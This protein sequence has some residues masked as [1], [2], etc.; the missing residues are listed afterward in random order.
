MQ[1]KAR[2]MKRA[3][4]LVQE[5]SI[6]IVVLY[7]PRA[8][9]CV[10]LL[11]DGKCLRLLEVSGQRPVLIEVPSYV[12]ELDGASRL[13]EGSLAFRARCQVSDFEF[14]P[15]TVPLIERLK[16]FHRA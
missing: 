14:L 15:I 13:F 12:E 11:A 8:T 9:I 2:R 6:H 16:Y 5:V 10:A 3:F 4:V 1:S 7:V